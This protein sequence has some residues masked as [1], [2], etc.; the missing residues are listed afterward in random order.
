MPCLPVNNYSYFGRTTVLQI[1]G[2][3]FSSCQESET[4][5]DIN[6]QQYRYK[7]IN[8]RNYN[9]HADLDGKIKINLFAK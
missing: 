5:E 2:S 1:V 7:N 8:C 3:E 9:L 6:F 4:P